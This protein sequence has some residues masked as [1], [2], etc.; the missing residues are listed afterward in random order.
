MQRAPAVAQIP[1]SSARGNGSMAR[2][3]NRVRA[4][5]FEE[6]DV[7]TQRFFAA[8][9]GASILWLASPSFAQSTTG[10]S[11]PFASSSAST[12]DWSSS[13][14]SKNDRH[15]AN[16]RHLGIG[17][18]AGGLIAGRWSIAN[19]GVFGLDIVWRRGFH[20][21]MR[22]EVGGMGRIGVTRD[23]TLV[24]GGIPIRFVSSIGKRFET[25]LGLELSYT[26][27]IF[28][29]PFFVP[30][31]G[32]VG[33]SRWD[34]GVVVDPGLSVGITPVSLSLIAGQRVDPFVTYEPGLWIRYSP[35]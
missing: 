28:S 3:A 9:V 8:L 19:G 5:A 30:R 15:A 33:T 18:T 17:L 16:G 20:P 6:A 31:H 23:A 29:Q 1:V 22:M 4:F 2:R 24:G 26:N 32:F 7:K 14:A 21:R 25:A 12:N 34:M 35:I 13:G 27:M 10:Q 11:A